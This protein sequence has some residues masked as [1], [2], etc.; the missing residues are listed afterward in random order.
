MPCAG[1]NK[2]L[3]CPN[4]GR[5]NEPRQ[6]IV[7]EKPAF[8]R[9]V[10]ISSSD[11]L[12]YSPHRDLV[13][14]D[15]TQRA[16]TSMSEIELDFDTLAALARS[17]TDEVWKEA[18]RL[19]LAHPIW[20]GSAVIEIDPRTGQTLNAEDKLLLLIKQ[21]D[22]LATDAVFMPVADP[23]LASSGEDQEMEA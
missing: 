10:I 12:A 2:A 9:L 4:D 7:F 19:D 21:F 15:L 20:D 23:K 8:H 14:V 5:G 22:D 3:A 1:A 16:S 6:T 13:A 11:D 18:A 17:A